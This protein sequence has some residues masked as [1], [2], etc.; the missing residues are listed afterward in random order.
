MSALKRALEGL[1]VFLEDAGQTPP[2]REVRLLEIGPGVGLDERGR[3]RV[4]RD[5]CRDPEDYS[6]R[7]EEVLAAGFPWINVSC[8][9][10]DGGKLIV[11][12]EVPR[13]GGRAIRTSVNYSGPIRAT[14][15]HGWDATIALAIE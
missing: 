7:F 2:V 11:V 10:V 3:L 14:I 1:F 13:G 12:V 15:E 4:R 5:D 9:G 6:N 8:Y